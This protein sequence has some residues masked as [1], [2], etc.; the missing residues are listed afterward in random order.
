MMAAVEKA[1]PKNTRLFPFFLAPGN[2]TDHRGYNWIGTIDR[3]EQEQLRKGTGEMEK[4]ENIIVRGARGE[5]MQKIQR[6]LPQP[7]AQTIWQAYSS[8]QPNLVWW[9]MAMVMPLTHWSQRKQLP[10]RRSQCS[11]RLFLWEARP[12]LHHLSSEY[13]GQLRSQCSMEGV[14]ERV[15]QWQ[16]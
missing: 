16:R 13:P 11:G 4:Q 8:Y 14:V 6:P 2:K 9:L 7:V 1:D 10:R 5:I 15:C 12:R 3:Y